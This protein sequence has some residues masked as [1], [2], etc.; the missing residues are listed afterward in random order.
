M[1]VHDRTGPGTATPGASDLQKH[2]A[3]AVGVAGFE[4]TTSASRTQRAT[5]LRYTPLE[6]GQSSRAPVTAGPAWSAAVSA[7][8]GTRVSSVASGGQ[9][10]RTGAYGDVPRPAETCS[11]EVRPPLR[12]AGQAL[13]LPAG[14]VAVGDQRPEAGDAQ[15]AA[16]RVPGEHEREAVGDHRVEDP[17]VRG[18]G[19]ARS[20]GPPRGRAGRTR[21]RS[22][23]ARCAGRP[24]RPARSRGGRP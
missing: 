4:P 23:R 19:D 15:L 13:G 12:P 7:S 5:K 14:Q 11:H 9:A 18:V 24:C 17:A 6:P 8:R 20:R 21:R 2:R 1:S 22:G 3:S 10:K 16:V